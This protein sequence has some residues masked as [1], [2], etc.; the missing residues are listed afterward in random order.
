MP[1]DHD[2][3]K[4]ALEEAQEA[5]CRGEVPVGAVLVLE[6]NILAR[7]HNSPI[8]RNDPTAHAE[9]LALRQAG[10]KFGNYRLTGAELYVTLEP[11]IMCAGAIIQARLSRVI[12]GA[13][14]PKCGAV[15]SLYNILADKRL[16]HQVEITE[17]I[18]PEECGEI[19]S[20]FFQQKRVTSPP[21][22]QRD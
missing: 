13:R 20:R 7:A 6:G 22:R 15:V 12:F 8:M 18:L 9:I 10:E 1:T 16:N 21:L 19:I 2:F 11:C 3:M 4:I 14:D 5:Y 17:G